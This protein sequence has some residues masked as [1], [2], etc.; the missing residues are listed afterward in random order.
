M[1]NNPGL[2]PGQIWRKKDSTVSMIILQIDAEHVEKIIHIGILT[3]YIIG[4]MPFSESAIKKS[5]LQLISEGN[6]IPSYKE[7]YDDWKRNKGG[8][9]SF[10]VKEAVEMVLNSMVV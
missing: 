7:G 9:F 1:D 3:P 2:K 8:I 5:D 10:S 4:H 6:E